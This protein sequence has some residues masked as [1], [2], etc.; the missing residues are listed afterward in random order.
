M[1]YNFI[2]KKFALFILIVILICSMLVFIGCKEQEK[3]EKVFITISFDANGIDC[4]LPEDVVVEVSGDCLVIALPIPDDATEI[5]GHDLAWFVDK[6]CKTLFSAEYLTSEDM[7]LYLGYAPKTYSI[8]YTNK[9]EFEF[10]GEFKDSY[11]F[12]VGVPLPNVDLGKGYLPNSGNWYYGDAENEYYTTAIPKTVLGDLVLTFKAKPIK[13]NIV[14]IAN[15]P[16]GVEMENLN[17]T[18]YDVT[19]GTVVLLPPSAEGKTFSHWEYRS[20]M[21]KAKRI[22]QLD[23]D[24]FLETMSFSLWAVWE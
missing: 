23:L 5:T 22:E 18:Q 20:V 6:D 13:Y 10:K 1:W 21:S 16:E 4:T 12:G 9:D 2:V 8:T 11:V 14:Y 24:L 15:L 17:P 7:T 3:N 19:M